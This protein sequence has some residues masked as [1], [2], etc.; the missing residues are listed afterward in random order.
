MFISSPKA[1]F[2]IA[3]ALG[4]KAM[5]DTLLPEGLVP[6]SL[7]FGDLKWITDL[8]KT[9]Q[10]LRPT[11]DERAFL[12]NEA[13][14]EMAQKMENL[15]VKRSLRHRTPASTDQIY[16][17][18]DMPLVWRE[19]I[20]N[21]RIGEFLGP[22]KVRS[23]NCETKLVYIEDEKSKSIQPF[24]TTQ[25]KP[26]ILPQKL[27]TT[28]M[29]QLG[30]ALK[31]FKSPSPSDD[32]FVTKLLTRCDKRSSIPSIQEA[33]QSEMESLFRRGKFRVILKE[34]VPTNANV[35]PGRFF[36]AIKSTKDGKIKHKAGFVIGG[37]RDKL[38]DFMVHSS[39]TLQPQHIR[40]LLALAT[41][42]G[43]EIW[44]SDVT[45]AYLQSA[46]PH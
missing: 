39:Q 2:D 44:N 26:Y 28:Y 34:E 21:N 10:P 25:V 46:L 24:C 11:T 29:A 5:N 7:V 3:L 43:I 32:I 17:P 33:R 18:G 31:R 20:V 22:Y 27:S 12:A 35:L 8:S 37:H 9:D 23:F 1:D 45:H 40:L 6:L 15:L 30:H 16:I 13:C 14:D 36:L 42:F 41:S 38:K 19:N 4:I